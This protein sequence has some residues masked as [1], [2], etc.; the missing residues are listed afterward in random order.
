MD[1]T[2]ALGRARAKRAIRSVGGSPAAARAENRLRQQTSSYGA[3][4]PASLLAAAPRGISAAERVAALMQL[5]PSDFAEIHRRVNQ[6]PQATS[7][8]SEVDSPAFISGPIPTLQQQPPTAG[9][10]SPVPSPAPVPSI[11]PSLRF[12]SPPNSRPRPALPA[13]RTRPGVRPKPT[14]TAKAEVGELALEPEPEATLAATFGTPALTPIMDMISPEGERKRA[15]ASEN[16]EAK[17][18]EISKERDTLIEQVTKLLTHTE[19]LIGENDALQ[20]RAED[21]EAEVL[22]LQ[23]AGGTRGASSRHTILEHTDSAE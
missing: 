9:H 17:Y 10:A 22:N 3:V 11:V 5:P 4:T 21:A 13:N 1:P 16:W 14:A 2:S 19:F 15:A 12:A 7:T 23:S 8:H 20:Q 6:P 18:K